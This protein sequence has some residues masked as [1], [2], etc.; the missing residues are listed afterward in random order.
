MADQDIEA[1]LAPQL[2]EAKQKEVTA[3]NLPKRLHLDPRHV[4][5]EGKS[6]Y[7]VSSVASG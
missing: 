5:K 7:R 1:P 3:N 4:P 6:R 2:K